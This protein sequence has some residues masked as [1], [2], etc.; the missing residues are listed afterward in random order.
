MQTDNFAIIQ[1]KGME[2]ETKD[3]ASTGMPDASRHQ[4]FHLTPY[5]HRFE[6]VHENINGGIVKI[7]IDAV[8][9]A[10]RKM[11]TDPR[12]KAEWE[13]INIIAREKANEGHEVFILPEIHVKDT[14][15]RKKLLP[16]AIGAKNQD[17]RIN[18][19]LVEVKTPESVTL[20]AIRQNLRKASKQAHN[21]I[22]NMLA[23]P[24]RSYL[25]KIAN[26]K[27]RDKNNQIKTIEFRDNGIYFLFK[28][29]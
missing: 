11:R 14:E 24:G 12:K 25:D 6:I 21:I 5:E 22:I 8:A 17:L 13:T 3:K 29:K 20:D 16:D 15:L 9:Q 18:G 28:P 1:S 2:T 10:L 26:E 4:A 23:N 27:F 19:N 7:H